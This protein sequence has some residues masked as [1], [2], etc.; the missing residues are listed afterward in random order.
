MVS[1]ERDRF[2]FF[3]AAACHSIVLLLRDQLGRRVFPVSPFAELRCVT[4]HFARAIFFVVVV[5]PVYVFPYFPTMDDPLVA[6][7]RV[8]VAVGVL[9]AGV[10]IV[11][12]AQFSVCTPLYNGWCGAVNDADAVGEL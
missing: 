6:V 3:V 2:E 1:W 12:C 8:G 5:Y 9:A 7:V 11:I 4:R 10:R